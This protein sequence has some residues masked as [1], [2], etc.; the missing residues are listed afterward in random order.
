[1][2]IDQEQGGV[3]NVQVQLTTKK[4]LPPVQSVYRQARGLRNK[5]LVTNQQEFYMTSDTINRQ[6]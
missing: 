2:N 3:V 5:R 1:M 4:S 6:V